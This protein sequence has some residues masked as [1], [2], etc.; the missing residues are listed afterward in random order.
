MGRT[1]PTGNTY[2]VAPDDQRFLV[3]TQGRVDGSE[4]D[5]DLGA[6]TVL[7]QNFFEELKARVPN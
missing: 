7:V 5:G 6:E 4:E 1:V 2:D 3:A